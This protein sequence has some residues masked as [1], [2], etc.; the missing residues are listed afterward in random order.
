MKKEEGLTIKTLSPFITE[1]MKGKYIPKGKNEERKKNR[2]GVR[3]LFRESAL[4]GNLVGIFKV[5][6]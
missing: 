1:G 3:I 4:S 5:G 2:K 6:G